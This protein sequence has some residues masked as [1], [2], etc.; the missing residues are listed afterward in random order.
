ME[1]GKEG[2]EQHRVPPAWLEVEKCSHEDRTWGG[3]G[4]VLP[5]RGTSLHSCCTFSSTWFSPLGCHPSRAPWGSVPGVSDSVR[6]P[7]DWHHFSPFY[8][9]SPADKESKELVVSL[10]QYRVF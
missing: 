10:S 8:L 4:G 1:K 5:G 6:T 3:G 2:P 9:S 7:G